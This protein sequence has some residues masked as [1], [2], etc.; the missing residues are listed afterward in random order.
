M[1]GYGQIRVLRFLKENANA[2]GE[3]SRYIQEIAEAVT[4]SR[5]YVSEVTSR[6][7]KMGL[8]SREQTWLDDDDDYE[9]YPD[10]NL[11]KIL[12]PEIV[13]AILAAADE[14]HYVNLAEQLTLPFPPNE[15]TVILGHKARFV[16]PF[17]VPAGEC[18]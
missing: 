2:G 17:F 18:R 9:V 5:K 10:K 16:D 15:R 4:L 3:C 13:D 1:F 14:H 11:Y 6:F 8:I 7:V 12:Q